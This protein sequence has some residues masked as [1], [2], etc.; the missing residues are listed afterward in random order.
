MKDLAEEKQWLVRKEE[1]HEDRIF[2]RRCEEN[3][4]EGTVSCIKKLL[5]AHVK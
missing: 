2:S 3:V 1:N 4:L 5:T